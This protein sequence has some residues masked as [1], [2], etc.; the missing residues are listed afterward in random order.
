MRVGWE[1]I[2][3]YTFNYEKTENN[4]R[5]MNEFDYEEIIDAISIVDI[6][7]RT[8][9]HQETNDSNVQLNL[10]EKGAFVAI[11]KSGIKTFQKKIRLEATKTVFTG[12]IR[13]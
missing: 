6:L 4:P 2:D 10:Q 3:S 12:Y 11:I 5:M 7:G 9:L 1:V 8:V 13:L